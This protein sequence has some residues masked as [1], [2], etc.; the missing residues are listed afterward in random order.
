MLAHV[1][2]GEDSG[3]TLGR[4]FHEIGGD[5]TSLCTSW[6]CFIKRR[7]GD[8]SPQGDAFPLLLRAALDGLVKGWVGGPPCRTRPA[9]RHHQVEGLDMPRPLRAWNGGEHGIKGLSQF[10]KNQVLMD[11]ILL[12]RFLLL[13]I[14]SEEI[15]KTRDECDPVTLFIEQPA[16]QANMPEVVTL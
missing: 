9:L 2:S 7:S 11:D 1:F 14:V 4:A 3:Y 15:R 13:Y 16:D 8:L 5:R 10:E 6:M 12:M